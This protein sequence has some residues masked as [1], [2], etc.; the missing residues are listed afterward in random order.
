MIIR[1]RYS[2]EPETMA[3]AIPGPV[4]KALF[5]ALGTLLALEAPTS[6]LAQ[7]NGFQPENY[8]DLV[9]VG[10]VAVS[11]AGDLVAFTVTRI[12]E[13]ENR[14][15]R[16]LW[17]QPL[18]NGRPDGEAYPFTGPT[19]DSHS[20]IWSF[21]GSLLSFTSE[22]GDDDNS[23]W[24]VRVTARGGEA[25]H[26]DGV[27]GDPVWSQDGQWIAY[28]AKP[29][30]S[31]T[32]D[33]EGWV[34][35]DALTNTVDRERFDG[36]VITSARYKRDGTLTLQPHPS[37]TD[38]DELHL[39]SAAG[40]VPRRLTE[41]PFDKAD[42]SWSPDGRTLFFTGDELQ[43]DETNQDLTQDIWVARVTDGSVTR[44]TSNP[45]SEMSPAPS[46]DGGRLAFQYTAE[47]GAPQDLMVV[48]IGA[49]GRFEGVPVNLTADWDLDPGAPEWTADGTGILFEVSIGGDRHLFRV[50]ASAG[51]VTQVTRGERRLS[52]ISFSERGHI[53]AYAA[54]DAVSPT[55]LFVARG[56]GTGERQATALNQD[57]MSDVTLVAPER[58]IWSVGDDG[59]QI[60]GWVV[61]PLNYQAGG[62]YPLV[63]KIH[64]GPHGAYGNTFFPTF[65]VLSA[66]G[67]FVLYSNPRGSSAYGHEFKYATRGQW[68]VMDSE[69]F[70]S[71][72]D[73]ALAKYPDADATRLG[74]S[75]GSYGGYMTNWLTATSDRFHAAVT[76]RSISN[77]ESWWGSSDAQGLTRYEFYGEPWKRRDLYRR[78]SPISY[79]EN[80]TAPT[81]IIH[82]EK[83]FRTP[84][85]DG[86]QWFMALKK[87]G[88]PTEMV[89]YPRS[90]HGLSR[91]G[92][93]WLLVDRLERIRS[94][95]RHWLVDEPPA[96][97]FD[98]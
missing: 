89:R 98:R 27:R 68:G 8:Y 84:I 70:L 42:P 97:T 52:S 54:T 23:T 33:R 38:A 71:G 51:P 73:A 22:R 83:D 29:E 50:P 17:M 86:E 91:T 5:L 28:M 6:L 15:Q 59:V 87:L 25:F 75:G 65:H 95:F 77:W 64:G 92:E 74:V 53:M 34:A 1:C 12:L 67:F 46:P 7:Q 82:S 80:V 21:D 72:V 55:E 63:L 43:H 60:E 16:E 96:I 44:I 14:R 58:L 78:L 47:R 31:S 57:W 81:L 20:P 18:E 13:E 3:R 93:P 48:D 19:E 62:K 11:P 24:F 37:V 88:V 66:A 10:D 39:V 2:I 40:G 26:I 49:D 36:R 76:S 9:T 69:D 30:G 79:V 35:P 4:A 56:D 32:E 45:G 94:W 85:G 41:L 90:S 61:K